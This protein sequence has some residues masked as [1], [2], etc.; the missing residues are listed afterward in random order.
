M[1]H[2]ILTFVIIGLTA[3]LCTLGCYY[4]GLHNPSIVAAVSGGTAAVAIVS[5]FA[6]A[7]RKRAKRL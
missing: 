5:T 6:I 3:G 4:F 7:G 1:K 2:L